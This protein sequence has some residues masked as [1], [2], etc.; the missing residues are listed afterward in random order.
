MIFEP[1]SPLSKMLLDYYEQHYDDGKWSG[2]TET[3]S[4]T[5][6]QLK[7]FQA[8]EPSKVSYLVINDI[9][10]ENLKKCFKRKLTLKK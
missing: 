9:A 4:R 2:A 1:C 5:S 6:L 3:G 10:G 7:L 8:A